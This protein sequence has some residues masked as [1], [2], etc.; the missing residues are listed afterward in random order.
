MHYVLG[1]IA[2]VALSIISYFFLEIPFRKR[3][4]LKSTYKAYAFFAVN[5]LMFASIGLTFIVNE[6][7]PSRFSINFSDYEEHLEAQKAK[8][9][10]E[11]GR[12]ECWVGGNFARFNE[13][14][15][16]CT[17]QDSDVLVVGDSHSSQYIGAL[18][19]N[20][21]DKKIDQLS[22]SSC[23][24]VKGYVTDNRQACMALVDWFYEPKNLKYYDTVIVSV[25]NLNNNAVRD[26][27]RRLVQLSIEV[28][29]EIVFLGPIPYAS[30]NM[31]MTFP[32]QSG[33]ER[34]QVTAALR[35]TLHPRTFGYEEIYENIF[36]N[37]SVRYISMQ[38]FLCAAGPDSCD[39]LD[40]EGWPILIDNSHLSPKIAR[41]LI[42]K[43][44]PRL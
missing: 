10:V 32:S 28:D 17:S 25:Q 33:N 6:G 38:S 18:R 26:L 34:K 24:L 2:A 35:D 9:E 20:L 7:V 43:A 39:V 5:S 44:F 41:E 8:F 19:E 12:R 31:P 3:S 14:I 11:S 13:R 16:Q 22:V 21:H 36:V 27:A 1:T 40:R 4:I 37:S 29:V 15:S 30:P 23:P 42:S